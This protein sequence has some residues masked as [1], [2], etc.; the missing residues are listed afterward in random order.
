MS[1]ILDGFRIL[2][3]PGPDDPESPK[4]VGSSYKELR[5]PDCAL[6]PLSREVCPY[7]YLPSY[8]KEK[9][10]NLATKGDLADIIREARVYDQA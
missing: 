1:Y 5:T 8:T 2:D 10:K 3:K 7:P 4:R 9:G 6:F